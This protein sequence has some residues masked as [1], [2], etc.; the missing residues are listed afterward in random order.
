VFALFIS[1][2]LFL[3]KKWLESPLGCPDPEGG[4]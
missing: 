3:K 4:K 1:F 2:N